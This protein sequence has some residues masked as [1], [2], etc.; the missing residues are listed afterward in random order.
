MDFDRSK[1]VTSTYISA[2]LK[3]LSGHVYSCPLLISKSFRVAVLE[4]YVRILEP[5]TGNVSCCAKKST[6]YVSDDD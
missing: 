1:F 5:A 3:T 4:S 6:L 2:A